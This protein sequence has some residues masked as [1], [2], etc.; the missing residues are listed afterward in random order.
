MIS[1]DEIADV[2]HVTN[3]DGNHVEMTANQVEVRT[4]FFYGAQALSCKVHLYQ[5]L[6]PICWFTVAKLYGSYVLVN[7]DSFIVHLLTKRF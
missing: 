1:I 5:R 7:W 6:D 2:K 4:N 3:I